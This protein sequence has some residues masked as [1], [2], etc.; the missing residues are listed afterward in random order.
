M[1]GMTNSGK[2]FAD[3]LTEF[4]PEAGFIQYNVR[5]L[6]IIS[7]HQMDQ[8]LFSYLMLIIVSIGI[9]MKILEN[10]LLI[11]WDRDSM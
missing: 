3:D 9:Q 2:L 10:G 8:N 11:L 5:C 1:Y 4:L 7:M 6:Y